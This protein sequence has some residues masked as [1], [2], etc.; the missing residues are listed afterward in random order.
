[1]DQRDMTE[2]PFLPSPPFGRS[3]LLDPSPSIHCCRRRETWELDFGCDTG[4]D[5]QERDPG[6]EV[7]SSMLCR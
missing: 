3:G 7:I 2:I 6:I 4:R 5:L 1:M